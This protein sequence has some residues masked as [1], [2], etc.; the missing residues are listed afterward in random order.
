MRSWEGTI[1]WIAQ[2]PFRP[3]HKRKNWFVGVQRIFPPE[4][5]EL[6]SKDFKFESMRASGP[7]GQHVNK[8]NS[9]IRVTHLPTGLAT[10]AQEERSQHMNKKLALSRLLAKIQEEQDTRA[11]QSQQEQWGMHN[12]LERG[13]PVRVFE[14][15][16]FRERKG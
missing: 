11:Q 5:K 9:A 3:R 7:G 8:V 15:E 14:G 6:S 10:M 1:Q 12:D 2:S 16:R 4:E 13:N